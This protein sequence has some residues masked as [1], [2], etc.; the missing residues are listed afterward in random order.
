MSVKKSVKASVKTPI[1]KKPVKKTFATKVVPLKTHKV[2][3][4]KFSM[5][6]AGP[7]SVAQHQILENLLKSVEPAETKIKVGKKWLSLPEI[8]GQVAT[9]VPAVERVVKASVE[10]ATAV[11]IPALTT[12][13]FALPAAIERV[14]QAA[15]PKV[16]DIAAA[17]L[18]KLPLRI[19]P[20][21]DPRLQ[22]TLAR[23]GMGLP[24]RAVVSAVGD[25][26]AVIA[27][28]NDL[29][30]W[31]ALSEVRV[32]DAFGE[33]VD[34]TYVVTARIPVSRIEAVRSQPFV[35]SLKA[36]QPLHPALAAT[37]QEMGC[38]PGDF[39]AKTDPKGGKGVVV[40]IVDFG[41]DFAHRNFR[42]ADGSTRLIAFWN[43][44]GSQLA[45]QT[46]SYGR[47]YS[48]A[49]I[50]A[51]LKKATPYQAL[52]YAPYEPPLPDQGAHG[53]HVMDIAA[54]NGLGTGV[55]G[56]APEA[57]LVFVE[58]STSDIERNIEE[59]TR[60]SFGDSAQMLEAVNFIFNQAG[61]R[62]CVVN[63]SLGT[64]GGPH[65]G[66][67]L[68]EQGLDRL[69][70]AK[71][72]R[73]VVIACSNSYSDGIH[74][75]GTVPAAG[76]FDLS[77]DMKLGQR[78][79]ELEIWIPGAA[80]VAVEIIDPDGNSLG[81]AEPGT[82]L[83][84]G[85]GAQIALFLSNRLADP[86]NHDNAVGIF[87]AGGLPGGQW[88]VRLHSRNAVA[89]PFHAWVERD[90]GEQ[91]SFVPPFDD[92]HTIGSI[93]CGQ[94]TI[95]VGSFDAHKTSLPLSYFSSAGPTRDGR[96]K[97]EL[98]APGH[99]VV[100]ARS[101]T[102]QGVTL[103]SGTSMAAPAV[104]GLVALVLAEALRKKVSMNSAQIRQSLIDT[105]RK[106]PPPGGAW[107]PRYG[108]GRAHSSAVAKVV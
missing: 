81:I 99:D 47:L 13:S 68:V 25:E 78:D 35:M 23:R 65:D 40:G 42:R 14:A 102:G 52:G 63:L 24:T 8:P 20:N 96:Q 18:R 19:V 105:V 104:A 49:E 12:I 75:S 22:V 59:K 29:A 3:H 60:Q 2:G 11:P 53:T 85:V 48:E 34:G 32:G 38:R 21:L 17:A 91:S 106:N 51:A 77:W 73:A 55:A 72:N 57:D 50:N 16:K 54:G 37:T 84:L 36:S 62:P 93:S 94:E 1:K 107:D 74:A 82:N 76:T 27:K 43:Q 89:V 7:I 9:A 87:V 26:V 33:P 58:V 5:R 70:R 10:A 15:L 46:V 66:S 67:T 44:S 103:K 79:R 80:Q 56:C 41:C 97:P 45:N 61:D 39:P 30:A 83:P 31:E 95:V 6:R 28:V 64:N 86:N 69:V 98:S 4:F 88:T 92:T 71:P 101:R 108:F 90:N 100:A